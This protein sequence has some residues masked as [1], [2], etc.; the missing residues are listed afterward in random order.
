MKNNLRCLSTILLVFVTAPFAGDVIV[1]SPEKVEE[2]AKT[3]S[4]I[5]RASEYNVKAQ[6]NAV[7]SAF[8]AFLPTVSGSASATHLI[9]KPQM[10]IGGGGGFPSL[11]ASATSLMDAGDWQTLSALGLMFSNITIE[12]PNNLYNLGVNIAQPLF[13]GGKIVNGY[14]IAKYSQ[15][16]QVYSHK[17]TVTEIGLTAQRFFWGYVGAL[18][19]YESVVETRQWFETLVK[20]QQKMFENGLIIELDVLNSK[21]QLDNFKLA[22]V[23][24]QNSI[25]TLADQLLL[26]LGLRQGVQVEVDTSMLQ[27]AQSGPGP[28]VP[29]DSIERWMNGR[30][31]LK[32][33]ASQIEVLRCLRKL[34]L[35]SY[36]PSLV[37]FAGLGTNNQYS[38][39]EWD[40]KRNSSFGFQLNWTIL[41]WGKAW[42]DGLKVQNQQKAFELQEGNM[43]EQIRLRYADLSRKVDESRK[44][45]EIAQEDL[46]TSR[47]ALQ[48]ARLKYDAQAITNTELLNARNQLTS[49]VVSYTQARINVILAVAEFVVAPLG[50]GSSQ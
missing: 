14:K 27:A 26:F 42:Q 31:D 24:M 37:A 35:G 32:A 16:A 23:K 12:T 41:D 28:M 9:D 17:R 15:Q 48:I 30:D 29:A 25:R 44:A 22:E 34:Q 8:T 47:K 7:K 46:E 40:M 6:E 4:A 36:S 33:L 5:V 19:G 11:P 18:K 20:D 50:S 1:L 10:E 3:Q 49:K 45:C 2:L 39:K 43:R 13:T 38:I 21:L